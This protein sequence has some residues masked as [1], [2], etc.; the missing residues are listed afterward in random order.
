M[1]KPMDRPNV[2]LIN[3]DDMGY[4]DV[5]CYGSPVNKTPALDRMA[6]EGLKL[7]DF[8]MAAPVC[9][10]SRGSLMTG[11]YPPR[12]GL[13]VVEGGHWVLFPGHGTG[14]STDEVTIAGLLKG[15]G[16]ATSHIGKWHLG[17]QP[18]FLPTRHGFDHY[19][20][21]PYSNDM[22]RQA[23]RRT[24][25][26]PLPLLRDEEVIQ[27]Q[28]DQAALTE[29][30]V[31]EAVRFIRGNA[32][33]PFFLYLA[34]MY[35]HL[36]VYAPQHFVDRSENGR[37]GA[38]VECVDWS[39]SVI[40]WELKR[41][42]LDENTIVVFTSD[43][44]S[45]GDHGGSNAPLRGRKGQTLEGG[46]RVPCIVRWPGVVPAGR[47]SGEVATAMDLLPTL[48]ALAG[49][50]AP[51]DRIIDG[52]DIRPILLG[53]EGAESPYDAFF[54]YMK[55]DL[56]AVRCGR[57]K[58][59]LKSG[60]LYDLVADIGETENVADAN[61]EVVR[62]LEAKAAACREDIGDDASG[63]EGANR[64]APGKVEGAKPLT[65]YDPDHP[66][67]IAMYDLEEAG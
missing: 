9:T 64:R 55:N 18:E 53:E 59:H 49:A 24:E 6:A 25:Y 39:V 30:Y 62:E 1:R 38:G 44:G 29:R 67:I 3:C 45:R 23:G 43:N 48:A 40:L 56:E 2:V 13:G 15:Q 57:W 50:A 14:L 19:Y 26:P 37:Y 7:T 41:L 4:G 20:G 46:M 11:C 61:P 8:Y 42:G 65:E 47:V 17:D 54:Y 60:E 36:P 52:K 28:P 34:H 5:G 31:E 63:V 51:A 21:L 33:R 35:V 22:G 32:D 58:L 16:Y 12:I 27:Q 66:Y 10:P